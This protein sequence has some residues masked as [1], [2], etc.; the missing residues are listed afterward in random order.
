MQNQRPKVYVVNEPLKRDKDTGEFVRLMDLSPA[1]AYGELE[2]L[3]PAGHPPLEMSG[4]IRNMARKLAAFTSIDY[5]LPVGHPA[6]IGA[7]TAL[8]ADATE[9]RVRMLCWHPG[10]GEYQI[11]DLD[12]YLE[13]ENSDEQFNST[14]RVI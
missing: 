9:G 13:Q 5:I 10:L 2:H 3:A 6:L 1:G 12:I 14:A 8:A 7:A 11:V 4:I